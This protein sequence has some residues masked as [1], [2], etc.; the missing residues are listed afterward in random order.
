MDQNFIA[1]LKEFVA[2]KSI[3]TNPAFSPEITKTVEWLR[4]I[5][6]E[7]NF[8]VELLQGPTCNPIVFAK[9]QIDTTLPTCLIYGHYDVQPSDQFELQER[10][11][12]LFGRGVVDNKGQNLIHIYSVC[13]LIKENKLKYNVKFLI[14]GNEETANNDLHDLLILHKDKL[15]S[16]IVLVSDGE[17]INERPTVD[18]SLRGGFNVRLI[19]RTALNNV[20][21]GI[22]GGAIPNAAYEMGNFISNLSPFTDGV[23][24]ISEQEI[25]NNK[26][27]TTDLDTIGVKKQIGEYDFYTQTGL[28]PTIQVTGFKSGYIDSG[29][30]NIV[31]ASAEVRL[32]FRIVSSQKPQEI[33]SLFEKYVSKKTPKYIEYELSAHGLH[34]PVKLNTISKLFVSTANILEEIYTKP[35]FY[36]N[37]GGAI[38]F[39]SDVKEVFGVDTLSV[40]LANSDCNMHGANENF[41]IDLIEKGLRFSQLF[42]SGH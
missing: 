36:Q 17:M 40:A 29:F 8:E 15:K 34:N 20:H 4:N 21:S 19:Y 11:G 41:R 37:C 3:S 42:F 2:F 6:S 22:Y 33:L 39:I 27:V 28:T 5:F 10:D 26:S 25:A 30:A 12:R 35:V 32:N 16:D 14:E 38:P 23:D 31:P 1:L 7:H 24:K 13:K 9:L 18:A